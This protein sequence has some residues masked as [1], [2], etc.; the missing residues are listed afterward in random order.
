MWMYERTPSQLLLHRFAIKS[1]TQN[2]PQKKG[3]VK[4]N[5]FHMKLDIV[6]VNEIWTDT[7]DIFHRSL[8]HRTP[9]PNPIHSGGM[10]NHK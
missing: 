6:F 4:E 2:T 8:T 1:Q 5:P 10:M 7:I 9:I 3:G